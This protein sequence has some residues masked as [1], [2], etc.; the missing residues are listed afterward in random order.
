[1]GRPASGNGQIVCGGGSNT[2]SISTTKCFSVPGF[3]LSSSALTP[4]TVSPGGSATS[5]VTVAAYGGL[6]GSVVFTCSV[7]PSSILAPTCSISPSS[8]K[9]GTTT[10]TVSTTAPTGALLPSA[11]PGLSY[12]LWLPLFGL[13]ATGIGS[14]ATRKDRKA[15]LIPAALVCMLFAGMAVQVGCGGSSAKP[16]TPAGPYTVTVTGTSGSVVSSTT[17]MLTVQ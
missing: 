4:A 2:V 17:A 13:V 9:S 8:V 1:M 12:A 7:Q 3:D 5:T 11:G 10:L 6:G 16:G 15:N 14:R